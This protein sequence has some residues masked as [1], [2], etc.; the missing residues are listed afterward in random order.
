MKKKSLA[1][2]SFS[3]LWHIPMYLHLNVYYILVQLEKLQDF[4]QG[5]HDFYI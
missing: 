1:T 3:A 5:P 2:T 4:S